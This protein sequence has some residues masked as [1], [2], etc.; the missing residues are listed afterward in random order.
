LKIGSFNLFQL[1]FL[2]H[3]DIYSSKLQNDLAYT[4]YSIAYSDFNF[5]VFYERGYIG[6]LTCGGQQWI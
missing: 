6:V 3:W 5:Y 4:L 1:I 2:A